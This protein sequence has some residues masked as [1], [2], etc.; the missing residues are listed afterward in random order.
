M[1]FETVANIIALLVIAALVAIH[2]TAGR[3]PPK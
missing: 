3:R 1:T 2:Y